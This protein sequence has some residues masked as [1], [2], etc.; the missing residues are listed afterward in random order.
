MDFYVGARDDAARAR[1]ARDAVARRA[2]RDAARRRFGNATYYREEARRVSGLDVFDTLAQD[3]SLRPAHASRARRLFTAVAV[4][5]LAIG[6]GA[7]TAIFSAV[8]TLLLA[9]LPFRA[10]ERS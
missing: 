10:P 2:A 3:V 9:P 7:N 5:T 1:R 6:I 4:A 8:D